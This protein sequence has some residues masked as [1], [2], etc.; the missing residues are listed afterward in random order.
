MLA[1][2]SVRVF[3]DPEELDLHQLIVQRLRGH[4]YGRRWLY[5]YFVS[6]VIKGNPRP[7]HYLRRSLNAEDVIWL[8]G[9][10]E[11]QWKDIREVWADLYFLASTSREQGSIGGDILDRTLR[12]IDRHAP[13]VPDE[14][15]KCKREYAQ[16]EREIEEERRRRHKD[17]ERYAIAQ[18]VDKV[19]QMQDWT[20]I[21]RMRQLSLLCFS[22]DSWRFQNVD[23]R[24]ADLDVSRQQ[25]ILEACRNGLRDGTPTPFP[26][27]KTFTTWNFAEAHAFMALLESWPS[28]EWLDS[29]MIEKWLPTVLRTHVPKGLDAVIA[30]GGKDRPATTTVS[31][32]MIE[33]VLKKGENHMLFA[34]FIPAGLWPG[35]VAQ[36]VVRFARDET[37]PAATRAGLLETLAAYES[38]SALP[39]AM[40][41]TERQ[42]T[43]V[44]AAVLY[45]K[46]LDVRLAL[47]AQNAW[48]KV[49]ADYRQR[50]GEALR[51]LFSVLHGR[52]DFGAKLSE[53]PTGQLNRLAQMLVE[54]FPLAV[55]SGRAPFVCDRVGTDD[56]LRQ[57]RAG[58]ISILM[59]RR[60]DG[61]VDA[62]APR[63]EIEPR[64]TER[65]E[66]EKQQR[67]A[68]RLLG[69]LGHK[70]GQE[71]TTA[72]AA[73]MPVEQVVRLLDEA[74]YRLIRSGDDLLKA[75]GHV[76]KQIG[77][78]AG[79]DVSMLYGRN[80]PAKPGPGPKGKT[81]NKHVRRRLE[82]DA[83]Q[84]YIRRRCDDLLPSRIPGV[85]IKIYRE[86]Q[87]KY[88]RRFDLQIVAPTI[89]GKLASVVIEMKWSDNPETKGGLENQFVRN[90]LLGHA[91]NYGIYLVAWCGAWKE[92]GNKRK[93]IQAL[94]AYLAER[95]KLVTASEEGKNLRVE[96]VV[97]DLRWRDDLPDE[98]ADP[99][100]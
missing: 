6:N 24:W 59:Q 90:Y 31:M 85:E 84:A 38:S 42:G 4:A 28:C 89:D 3:S 5:Q 41:W 30:C 60:L 48:P 54:T 70:P 43:G 46:A 45:H 26:D 10:A 62:L 69:H 76:L 36:R 86:P 23:G 91:L 39:L 17:V 20:D 29:P 63:F 66:W 64:L 53:W 21:D 27:E 18:V 2:L 94:R 19:L 47:D 44:D 33:M 80:E 68:S 77:D 1:R 11:S 75:I 56:E 81:G 95:V 100:E 58:V 7:P 55:E 99:V 50:G 88:Q 8:L 78:G 16:Q 32:A 37:L 61:D 15:E 73:G 97:L 35:E 49:E 96:P 22:G 74:G 40:E 67:E 93:N 72:A 79:Y 51:D 65:F 87:V 34:N 83:L 71:T 25:G 92:K 9:R 14:F 13:T 57:A 82:E 12:A 98:A 52:G